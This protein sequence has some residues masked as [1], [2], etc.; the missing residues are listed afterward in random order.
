MRDDHHAEAIGRHHIDGQTHTV[1][2]DRA[3]LD[4]E[5]RDGRRQLDL[6]RQRARVFAQGE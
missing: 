4:D 6:E 3:L 2:G 1:D 5:G